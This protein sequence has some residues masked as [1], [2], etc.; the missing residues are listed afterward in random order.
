MIRALDPFLSRLTPRRRP[1]TSAQAEARTV[2]P[3]TLPARE[4]P[5]WDA[6]AHWIE[7]KKEW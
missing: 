3:G 4:R 2:A 1:A 6:P 7:P 5:R